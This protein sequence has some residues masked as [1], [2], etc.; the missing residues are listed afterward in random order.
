MRT[1]LI[2][3]LILIVLGLYFY[4]GLT[5]NAIDLTGQFISD[6]VSNIFN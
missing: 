4:P 2:I 3:I 6:K 1:L 5:R